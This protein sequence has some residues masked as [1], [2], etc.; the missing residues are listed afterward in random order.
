MNARHVALLLA[1]TTALPFLEAD[2]RAADAL[3]G[4]RAVYERQLGLL[5]VQAGSNR[6]AVVVWYGH[7]LQQLREDLKKKADVDGLV[8]VVAEVERFQNGRSLP[9]NLTP[10]HPAVADLYGSLSNRLE[11]VRIEGCRR[12]LALLGKYLNALTL[13]KR[14]LVA[15]EKLT[16]AMAVNEEIKKMESLRATLEGRI[17]G[18]PDP[19]PDH[20]SES[21]APPKPQ[22]VAP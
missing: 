15:A 17:A 5:D 12:H 4:V 13:K 7:Q 11:Q 3:E 20:P 14:D 16:E 2:A 21:P 8:A 18:Q 22:A 1:A 19:Q 9:G 6:A 10:T